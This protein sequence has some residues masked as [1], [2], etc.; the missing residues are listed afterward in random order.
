[1][2]TEALKRKDSLVLE[3]E[4]VTGQCV[5]RP[6]TSG[7]ESRNA[8]YELL[9]FADSELRVSRRWGWF[10]PAIL[11]T[12]SLSRQGLWAWVSGGSWRRAGRLSSA[13]SAEFSDRGSDKVS[14]HRVK[15]SS[16]GFQ[17]T[18]FGG[19]E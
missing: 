12:V 16:H 3:S 18:E 15:S 6:F 10:H 1:M 11:T 13:V 4:H 8:L 19:G 5:K 9:R 17:S 14:P 7:D 2:I